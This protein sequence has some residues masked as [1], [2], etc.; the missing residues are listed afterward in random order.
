MCIQ[1]RLICCKILYTVVLLHDI[2]LIML[3]HI[4]KCDFIQFA[5]PL[6]S[7]SYGESPVYDFRSYCDMQLLICIYIFLSEYT[8]HYTLEWPVGKPLNFR[9]ENQQLKSGLFSFISGLPHKCLLHLFTLYVKTIRPRQDGRHFTGDTFKC[10]LLNE[11]VR[12]LI[13]I[14][15]KCVPKFR[16]N[17]F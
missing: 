2:Y 9:E 17:N 6:S 8:L 3:Q 12:K 13:K 11:N 4:T 15:L 5:V 14:S 16:I 7:I 10:I 1:L